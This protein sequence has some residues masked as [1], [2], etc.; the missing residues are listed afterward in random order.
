MGRTSLTI[1]LAAVL[2]AVFSR[3]WL[4]AQVPPVGIPAARRALTAEQMR[5]LAGDLDANEFLA[6]ETAMLRLIAAGKAAIPV[7]TEVFRDDSLEATSRALHILQQIGLSSDQEAQ[8]AALA[9]LIEASKSREN[10]LAARRAVAAIERLTELRSKQS[11]V[12]LKALGAKV[13]H[14]QTFDGQVLDDLVESVEIGP[15]FQGTVDDLRRLKWVRTGRLVLVGVQVSDAWLA[16]AASM[17]GLT[18]LHLHTTSVTTQ[19][20]AAI[21]GQPD[22]RQVGL[23]YT[24]LDGKALDHLAGLPALSLVKLYGTKIPPAAIEE[25]QKT[26]A[27]PVDARRGAFLGVGCTRGEN[28]CILSTVHKDSPA[29]KAGLKEQDLLVRF[30]KSKV[31]DFDTLTALISQLDAGDDVEVEVQR[32]ALDEQGGFRLKNVV[33]RVTLGPWGVEPAVLNGWRP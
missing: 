24:P 17:T 21:A 3:G 2:L 28:S 20:L 9:A 13:A 15:D 8:D 1:V 4:A 22:L 18:E 14:P 16:H 6:R 25:F 11:L 31:T 5:E 32:E 33:T 12:E 10:A 23:Y 19:G 30:G 26:A 7:V 29:E 27:I